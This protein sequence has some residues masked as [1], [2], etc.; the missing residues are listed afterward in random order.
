MALAMHPALAP[1]LARLPPPLPTREK[2]AASGDQEAGVLPETEV[3]PCR[4][5]SRNFAANVRIAICGPHKSSFD[6]YQCL[7]RVVD[8]PGFE[9]IEETLT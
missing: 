8:R 7:P 9:M 2:A 1:Q 3:R 5:A 4:P 6:Q